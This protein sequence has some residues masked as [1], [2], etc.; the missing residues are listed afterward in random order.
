M[1]CE[2]LLPAYYSVKCVNIYEE[3]V[4]KLFRKTYQ[5]DLG[6]VDIDSYNSISI[7]HTAMRIRALTT[8]VVILAINSKWSGEN[9]DLFIPDDIIDISYKPFTQATIVGMV[10]K[11]C[12]HLLI[13]PNHQMG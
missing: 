6:F 4:D 5:F 11:H 8:H 9:L 1:L 10:K 7:L 3:A 2:F 13:V 12:P